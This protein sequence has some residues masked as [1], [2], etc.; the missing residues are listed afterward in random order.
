MT[1]IRATAPFGLLLLAALFWLLAM[2]VAGAAEEGAGPLQR[3]T[4]EKIYVPA[5]SELPGAGDRRISLASIMTVHNVDPEQSI[6]LSKVSYHGD[7]GAVVQTLLDVPIDLAPL[8][9][10]TYQIG[11]ADRTGGIGAN[12]LVEWRSSAPALSPIAETLLYGAIGAQGISFTTR[13]RVI[14]RE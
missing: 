4:A 14:S 2:P 9:S 7:D 11:I 3:S 13:G 5:Y 6:T 12:F 8:A 1:G 10:W